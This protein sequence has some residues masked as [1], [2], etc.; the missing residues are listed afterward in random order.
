L[1]FK[2]P[3]FGYLTLLQHASILHNCLHC[4]LFLTIVNMFLTIFQANAST[5]A[6]T[7]TTSASSDMSLE[8]LVY[9]KPDALPLPKLNMIKLDN[10]E[11]DTLF[12]LLPPAFTPQ[13]PAAIHIKQDIYQESHVACKGKAREDAVKGLLKLKGL[14]PCLTTITVKQCREEAHQQIL[15]LLKAKT[16]VE[17]AKEHVLAGETFSFEVHTSLSKLH[18]TTVC[19]LIGKL[20]RTHLTRYRSKRSQPVTPSI[21][22]PLTPSPYYYIL[23][24][25]GNSLELVHM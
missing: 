16:T 18:D 12:I 14:D 17:A 13:C 19:V 9:T 15:D 21:I 3:I 20:D 23:N 8:S 4:P 25:F 24:V 11:N 7:S 22:E 2:V 6:T 5:T 1:S 10:L